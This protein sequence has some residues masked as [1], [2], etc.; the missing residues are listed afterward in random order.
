MTDNNIDAMARTAYGE[1]RGEGYQGM[2]GV[3]NVIM[4]RVKKQTWYGLTPYEVCHKCARLKSGVVVYQFTCW[5]PEDPNCKVITNVT[6]A[7]PIFKECLNI[8]NQ[9]IN[10]IL[11]DNTNGALNYFA[12]SLK[13]PPEWAEGKT[14]CA[15][16][17]NQLFYQL[18]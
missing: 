10:G 11:E 18:S 9:A 6:D 16:I 15:T 4:N 12:R 8:A 13:E 1:A 3:I 5:N 7:D 17:G 14:P 2:C